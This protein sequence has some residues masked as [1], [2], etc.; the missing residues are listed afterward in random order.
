M[1]WEICMQTE[2]NISI[3]KVALWFMA[4]AARCKVMVVFSITTFLWHI[5]VGCLIKTSLPQF[6]S[7]SIVPNLLGVCTLAQT[8]K[9]ASIEGECWL[10]KASHHNPLPV[11]DLAWTSHAT[12]ATERKQWT[13]GWGGKLASI[14]FVIKRDSEWENV[15]SCAVV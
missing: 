10:V 15:P 14:F 11:I 4:K 3:Q 2:E 5:L 8:F 13:W 9:R 6:S 12:P 7:K 1:C